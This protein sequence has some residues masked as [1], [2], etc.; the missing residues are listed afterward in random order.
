MSAGILYGRAEMEMHLVSLYNNAPLVHAKKKCTEPNTWQI[1]INI[2]KHE[3]VLWSL[4]VEALSAIR[5]KFVPS[6]LRRVPGIRGIQTV[7]EK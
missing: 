1:G 6:W 2:G 5:V 3:Q 7:L 4:V